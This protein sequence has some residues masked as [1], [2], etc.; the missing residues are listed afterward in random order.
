RACIASLTS[1]LHLHFWLPSSSPLMLNSPL[2]WIDSQIFTNSLSEVPGI[3]SEWVNKE[4]TA[5]RPTEER[6][7]L[8]SLPGLN[9][10]TFPAIDDF[11]PSSLNPTVSYSSLRSKTR[12]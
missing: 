5:R 6:L 11:V 12:L 7:N 10:T 4:T 1:S 2:D 9:T 8:N 3:S